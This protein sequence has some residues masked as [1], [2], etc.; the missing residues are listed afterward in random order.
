MG[1]DGDKLSVEHFKL[2]PTV[3]SVNSKFEGIFILPLNTF[4]FNKIV[5]AVVPAF[6]SDNKEQVASYLEDM[7]KPQVNEM[8]QDF[9]LEDLLDLFGNSTSPVLPESC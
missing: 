6:L 8:L 1:I 5:E 2:R 3:K 9:S 7:I 4:I